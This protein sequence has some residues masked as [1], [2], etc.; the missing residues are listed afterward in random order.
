MAFSNRQLSYIRRVATPL[1]PGSPA[2][3]FDSW[4]VFLSNPPG[5]LNA[6]IEIQRSASGLTL[7]P[8][9]IISS[10]TDR[11]HANQTAA[12]FV[13]D[14]T[15]NV[16]FDHVTVKGDATRTNKTARQD[17]GR[18]GGCGVIFG[19]N[20]S[21]EM[22]QCRVF[23]HELSGIQA[24][25]GSRMGIYDCDVSSNGGMDVSLNGGELLRSPS[26]FDARLVW[27]VT[28]RCGFRPA[29]GFAWASGIDFIPRLYGGTT[30]TN[31]NLRWIWANGAS[32]MTVDQCTIR[33][34]GHY[35][36]CIDALPTTISRCRIEDNYLDGILLDWPHKTKVEGPDEAAAKRRICEKGHVIIENYIVQNDFGIAV[37]EGVAAT[38]DGNVVE[39]NKE[40]GV[41]FDEAKGHTCYPC[42]LQQCR[43][44]VLG[45]NVIKDNEKGDLAVDVKRVMP[46]DQ[47]I[48][49]SER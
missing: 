44:V 46:T 19:Q 29:W 4:G 8:E 5:E 2:L 10:S 13:R 28:S 11:H 17:T 34:N 30:W 38:L 45:N 47:H 6:F 33:E 31:G 20:T 26:T 18:H 40:T 25:L 32:E 37:E 35:G 9:L 48:D 1:S 14:G 43:S 15:Q 21:G 39:R 22:R 16:V 12:V 27:S 42:Q 23:H 36:V 3:L 24:R 7:G 41:Y 49:L